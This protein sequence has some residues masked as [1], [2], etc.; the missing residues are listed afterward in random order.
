MRSRRRHVLFVLAENSDMS[1]SMS[2]LL[3][4][5]SSAD[6]EDK[7]PTSYDFPFSDFKVSPVDV[8]TIVSSY[9][10]R[11]KHE[12]VDNIIAF[13]GK[14]SETVLNNLLVQGDL[15]LQPKDVF[16]INRRIK[17][18]GE[19]KLPEKPPTT[20]GKLVWYALQDPILQI[21]LLCG[22]VSMVLGIA[23]G[24]NSSVDWIEGAAIFLAVFIVVL[25]TAGNDWLKERQF[26]KLSVVA[27]DR[28]CNVLRDGY[29]QRIKICAILV[30]DIISLQAGDEI[31]A[32]CV[33]I[34][35]NEMELDESS[36]SGENDPICKKNLEEVLRQQIDRQDLLL[37]AKES[38]LFR[39]ID[40]PLLLSGS[41]VLSGS[42]DAIVIA[43]GANSLVGTLAAKLNIDTNP[44]PLQ[45]KLG[46][47]AQDIGRA[48]FVASLITFL[49]LITQYTVIYFFTEKANRPGYSEVIDAVIR[50]IVEAITLI[51]VAVPEGLPLAVTI[52]LA[53]SVQKMLKDNNYVRRMAA[54]ETMGSA[55][56]ICSDKTGTLTMNEMTLT[57][58][59]NGS[60]IE[61]HV[62]SR[63][64]S[65]FPLPKNP[66]AKEALFENICINSSA[67]VETKSTTGEKR[68]KGIGNPT[69][70]ALLKALE[71]SRVADTRDYKRKKIDSIVHLDNFSSERKMMTTVID[72]GFGVHRILV[73]G[74][75]ER[76]IQLCR[77]R[78]DSKDEIKEFDEDFVKVIEEK[79]IEGFAK[80][81]LRTICVAY[82]DFKTSSVSPDYW[83]EF[84]RRQ[85]NDA[86]A[87]KL[88][89]R[90]IETD[91]TCLAIFGVNDPLRPEVPRAVAQCRQAGITTRM[92]TGD[93]LDT[94]KIIAR[95]SG[96]YEPEKGG[97]A[98]L[99]SEFTKEVG[100]VL[101]Q[102]C[103]KPV[104]IKGS[105]NESETLE[106][107][108]RFKEIEPYLQVMARSQPQDKY[109]LVV[110]LMKLGHVVAVTGDGTND[111]PALRRADVGFSFGLTGKETAK[112]ASDIVLLDDNFGSIVKAVIW[113]RSIFE[114][115]RKFLQ[116]QL[117]VN[118]SA[119]IT[120]L[121][122]A[123]LLQ[124]SP[125]T[126]VQLLWVNLIMDSLGSLALATEAPDEDLLKKKPNS[127]Q[128]YLISRAMWRNIAV[129]SVFQIT[130]MV[131][132]VFT[133]ECWLPEVE[134]LSV[135]PEDQ[136]RFPEYYP[137]DTT[138]SIGSTVR[139]GRAFHIFS[140]RP[141]YK[142]VWKSHFGA[143]R[144][145][146]YIFNIFVFMQ[147]FNMINA[148]VL[149]PDP[150]HSVARKLN[151]F[152]GVFNN[153][154]WIGIILI[155]ICGQILMI[156]LGG[157]AL[158]VHPDGL[159]FLQWLLCLGIASLTLVVRA[160]SLLIPVS[161][162]PESGIREKTLVPTY[163][164]LQ[165]QGPMSKVLSTYNV[166]PHSYE[167]MQ[168]T[169]MRSTKSFGGT[170]EA[171]SN[172]PFRGIS[173]G[174]EDTEDAML[175][176]LHT[177][178]YGISTLD[179]PN[180]NEIVKEL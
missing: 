34:R 177:A 7:K 37:E 157:I 137:Y 139:S 50:F 3:S 174:P 158:G 71:E 166:V 145:Y 131:L 119:V 56:Q 55:S 88:K 153:Y 143:S 179:E 118:I 160:L 76:I 95:H 176:S 128:D 66:V 164:L 122:G 65:K 111:A 19:N 36:L 124:D 41:S 67:Y 1:V 163:N 126:A 121:V 75:A 61:G 62:N 60:Q 173:E 48:G 135:L 26:R 180:E 11:R 129:Q 6:L 54:C 64:P 46:G 72:K 86:E 89:V 162:L 28:S 63:Y 23:T 18:Y 148:R 141:D 132:L 59:W 172:L 52:S 32:D 112:N 94:A 171:S 77:S 147:I 96:I 13:F 165:G 15:G 29:L 97:I 81:G 83:N 24:S 98:M 58:M 170:F 87:W 159:S 114:N 142:D 102:C 109:A 22:C 38:E 74:A 155:C 113:G 90:T 167:K 140:N 133:G 116:F 8:C 100:Q 30:G 73:K 136:L 151:V 16:D 125:L 146:T 110:G 82:K 21:L 43:V 40:S 68:T 134:G 107:M 154:L 115:V 169:R 120:A 17:H 5:T 53:F 51:I 35:A 47:L 69:E 91:L 33:V 45:S 39:I 42:G 12:E 99:G 127:R 49:I 178:F 168:P 93:N 108:D 25:V 31:P 4:R 80:K 101:C 161:Y 2:P 27:S 78:Y 130:V 85:S 123:I 150:A 10:S 104:C 149:Q 175:K 70:C 44:T 152:H 92:V 106:R 138:C 105:K 14:K 57:A 103:K 84:P 20:F 79:I 144:H 9:M 117:T 156:Q